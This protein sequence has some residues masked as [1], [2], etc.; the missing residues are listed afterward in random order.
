MRVALL[1]LLMVL[2]PATPVCADGGRIAWT[3]ERAGRRAAI[4]VAPVAPRVG[5][6]QL[7]WIGPS[8]GGGSVQA[9]H[10]SGLLVEASLSP[11][12]GEWHSILDLFAEGRWTIR[13]DPDGPGV[14]EAIEVPVEIGPAIPEWRTQWPWILAWVP[15]VAIGLFV[16][17]RRRILTTQPREEVG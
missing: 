6:V 10:E 4:V 13:L 15:M 14:E 11:R 8:D 3:G 2:V 17:V 12:N 16:A 5:T 1:L 9:R 7:D